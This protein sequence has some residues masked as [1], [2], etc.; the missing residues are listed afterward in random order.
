MAATSANAIGDR[1]ILAPSTLAR[2]DTIS[3]KAS[4]T[5]NCISRRCGVRALIVTPNTRTSKP[6]KIHRQY[7]D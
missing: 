4:A 5:A 7:R 1:M 2:V 6:P 3:S